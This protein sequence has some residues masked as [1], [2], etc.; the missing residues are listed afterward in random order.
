MAKYFALFLTT[1]ILLFLMLFC[2]GCLTFIKWRK[3]RRRDNFFGLN[4][5]EDCLDID[6]HWQEE[7]SEPESPPEPIYINVRDPL[8]R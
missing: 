6:H 1:L 3:N 8:L 7:E 5:G 2:C 4:N